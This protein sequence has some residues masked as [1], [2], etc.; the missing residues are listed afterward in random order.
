MKTAQNLRYKN[1][2]GSNSNRGSM[3][4]HIFMKFQKQKGERNLISEK[5]R[6]DKQNT[7]PTKEQESQ[8]TVRFLIRSR[9]QKTV[10]QDF[11]N[12]EGKYFDPKK[13]YTDKFSGKCKRK[14]NPFSDM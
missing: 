12:T 8:T 9:S 6:K 13:L 4:K 7:E 1:L 11:Q 10:V 2:R 14:I 3:F 5:E